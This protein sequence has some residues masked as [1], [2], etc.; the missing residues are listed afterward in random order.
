MRS[1]D[2]SCCL[3]RDPLNSDSKFTEVHRMHT[4]SAVSRYRVNR[5]VLLYLQFPT[6]S[7][8]SCVVNF[9]ASYS[10]FTTDN[11]S[12]EALR[13]ERPLVHR[14][15]KEKTGLTMRYITTICLNSSLKRGNNPPSPFAC[16]KKV[17]INRNAQILFLFIPKNASPLVPDAVTS[18]SFF[19]DR[20]NLRYVSQHHVLQSDLTILMLVIY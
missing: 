6:I 5:L 14:R 8:H 13:E 4:L 15:K 10:L 18:G 11:L 19:S 7:L 9:S 2:G 12:A 16:S 17:H 3:R 20:K 1:Q